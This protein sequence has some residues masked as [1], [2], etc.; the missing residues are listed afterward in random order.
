MVYL[1]EKELSEDNL[2]MFQLTKIFGINLSLSKTICKQIGINS[3]LLVKNLTKD[4][5]KSLIAA[6]FNSRV[7]INSDLKRYHSDVL[8]NLVEIKSYRGLRRISRLPVRG[9][10]THTNSMTCKKTGL[11]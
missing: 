4:Q 2:I 7:K 9:Q 5:K 10:R 11:V 8:K 6:V 3:T 1:F